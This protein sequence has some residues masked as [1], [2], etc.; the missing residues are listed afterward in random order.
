[1]SAGSRAAL[2]KRLER[3]EATMKPPDPRVHTWA[4][5]AGC[6]R[7]PRLTSHRA[8]NG[9]EVPRVPRF[10]N[11]KSRQ[12]CLARQYSGDDGLR[13]ADCKFRWRPTMARP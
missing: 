13:P 3:L 5:H 12:S 10:P 1:M 9:E 2:I 7:G 11:S 8:D 4:A 6:P